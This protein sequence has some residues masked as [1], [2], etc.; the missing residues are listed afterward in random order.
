MA[1]RELGQRTDHAMDALQDRAEA[2]AKKEW[3]DHSVAL[4]PEILPGGSGIVGGLSVDYGAILLHND[5]T[6]VDRPDR[7][8]VFRRADAAALAGAALGTQDVIET[9]DA[10]REASAAFDRTAA[11]LPVRGA[12]LSPKA[13]LLAPVADLG[14]DFFGERLGHGHG[15]RVP[16]LHLPR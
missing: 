1:V 7:G 12:P 3:W 5:G 8:L 2:D 11:V 10:L 9:R 13:D 15:T 6:W 14:T 16:R 4:V